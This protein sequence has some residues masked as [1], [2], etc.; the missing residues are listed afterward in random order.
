MFK[1]NKRLTFLILIIVVTMSA[2]IGFESLNPATP[3]YDDLSKVNVINQMN[4][5]QEIAKE[6]HSIYD[7]EAKE[8]VRT[9]RSIRTPTHTL[10]I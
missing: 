7:I 5:I 6:P 8:N 9:T 1:T 3:N 2:W 10:R 4:H